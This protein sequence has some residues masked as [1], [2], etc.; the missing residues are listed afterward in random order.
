MQLPQL[1]LSQPPPS[2]QQNCPTLDLKMENLSENPTEYPSSWRLV[3]IIASLYFGSFLIAL[4][5]NIINVAIPRISTDFQSLGDVAWYGT[6]YL[7]TITAFQP[8]F[9]SFYKF[10]NIAKVYK[11][12]IVIFEIGSV[13]CAAAP[14]SVAFI[15]GRAIAG[16]GAAGILQGALSIISQIVPLEKRP[17]YMGIVI[18]VFAVTVC[19]GPPLGGVFTQH[20]TWRWCFW[21]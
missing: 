21:M 16:L 18:S 3:I 8:I 15:F 11:T 6:A 19:A 14:S 2:S 4:D 5:T 17:L 12:S 10:F 1:R 13:L 20:A 9:G 7:L